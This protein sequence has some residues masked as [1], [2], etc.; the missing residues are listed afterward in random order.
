[1]LEE[2]EGA[3]EGRNQTFATVEAFTA[4]TIH[5]VVFWDVT[6]HSVFN[7]IFTQGLNFGYFG[8]KT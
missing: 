7:Q 8:I 2:I 1:M 5:V 3:I 6:P 4:I